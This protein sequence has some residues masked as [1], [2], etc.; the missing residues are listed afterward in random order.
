MCLLAVVRLEQLHNQRLRVTMDE[1]KSHA[2]EREI[3]IVTGE[4][5][6]TFGHA[7]RQC[8]LLKAPDNASQAELQILQNLQRSHAAKLNEL[9]GRFRQSQKKYM[10]KLQGRRRGDT[11]SLFGE[12][13]TPNTEVDTGFTGAQLE[14]VDNLEA[15]T[16][17]RTQE[18]LA[19]AKSVEDLATIFKELAVLV[20]DQGTVLDRIDY[21]MEQTVERVQKG[22]DE[23]QKVRPTT[24]CLTLVRD[25]TTG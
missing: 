25:D 5:T 19:I 1:E 4:I 10:A 14:M 6:A 8:K 17:A 21:N 16:N 2:D 23:L 15:E 9:S 11:L 20:I 22:V 12:S 18:I 7:G 3:E 24:A 13:S